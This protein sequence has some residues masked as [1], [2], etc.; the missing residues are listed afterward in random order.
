[1]HIWDTWYRIAPGRV[2]NAITFLANLKKRNRA[3]A[4]DLLFPLRAPQSSK[5]TKYVVG[6][7][8]LTGSKISRWITTFS[9]SRLA[10]FLSL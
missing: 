6:L 2:C 8:C 4:A 7:W 10:I 9:F 1:M 5:Y 3:A